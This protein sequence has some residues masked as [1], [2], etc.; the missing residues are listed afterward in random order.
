MSENP[1]GAPAQR[2]TAQLAGQ[3]ETKWQE[4][5]EELGTFYADNPTGDLA[6]PLASSNPYFILDMFPYPSGKGLHVGHPLGY[7]A[8]DTLA[9]YRRMKGDNVLYT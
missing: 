9:R 7:I 4:R 5:W 1:Q 8:T 3:I 2:Y 6:G